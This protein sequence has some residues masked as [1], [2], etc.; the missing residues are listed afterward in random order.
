M[1][2][3]DEPELSQFVHVILPTLVVAIVSA[4][5]F[6]IDGSSDGEMFWFQRSG[7]LVAAAGIY[8]G[9]HEARWSITAVDSH[10]F[11]NTEIWYRWLALAAGIIGTVIW[12]YGDIPF[13]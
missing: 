11:I 8:I 3:N 1:K 9:F 10:M 7:A 12:A 4:T 6:Y 2:G 13:K 5:S